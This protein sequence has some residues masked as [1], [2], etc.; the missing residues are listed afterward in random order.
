MEEVSAANFVT[1][2]GVEG[3]FGQ[4]STPL[5]AG[6]PVIAVTK[7]AM[8]DIKSTPSSASPLCHNGRHPK[9]R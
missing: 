5:K 4:C 1:G 6:A 2:R 9:G 8:S 3:V 7:G